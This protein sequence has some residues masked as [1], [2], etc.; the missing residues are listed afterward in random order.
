MLHHTFITLTVLEFRQRQMEVELRQLTIS[1]KIGQY[2][3]GEV[4]CD[5]IDLGNF[6][7]LGRRY[8]Y[9]L[10]CCDVI[11]LGHFDWLGRR[12]HLRCCDVIDLGHFDWLGR[13]Y[14]FVH[15]RVDI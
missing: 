1:L 3:Y 9:H 11:D 13:R 5:V 12:Y 6:D 2:Q 14:H 7:W 15:W 10:H 8:M 4:C